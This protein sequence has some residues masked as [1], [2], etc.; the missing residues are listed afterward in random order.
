M[1]ADEGAT[2]FPSVPGYEVVREIGRGG[3]AVVYE[4]RQLSVDRPVALKVV[5]TG[6]LS[7]VTERRFRD[8]LRA[9]GGLSWHPHVVGVHD[10]GLTDDGRPFLAMELVSGGSWGVRVR[11]DGPLPPGRVA[12]LGA[13]VADALQAAHDAGVVH[14][15]VKPDNVLVGR[16]DEALLADFGIAT[17]ADAT[18]TATGTFVGTIAYSPPELL[19]G[20]R[21]TPQSD[22][23]S[24]G[25]LLWALAVGRPAHE[26]AED[27]TPVASVQRVIAEPTP[28]VPEGVPAELAAVIERC[29][30][31][32]PFDRY[33]SARAVQEALAPLAEASRG[34]AA[35]PL[36][37]P[38]DATVVGP[39]PAVAD[40]A[41]ATPVG[42]DPTGPDPDAPTRIDGVAPAAAAAP[43]AGGVDLGKPSEPTPE[44]GPASV[45]PTAGV[46]APA[47]FP[48]PGPFAV[49][50]QPPA[51]GPEPPPG[52]W[53]PAPS[54]PPPGAPAL[55]P[56]PWAPPAD[57]WGPPAPPAPPPW[58]PPAPQWGAPAPHWGPPPAP[59]VKT[60]GLAIA[61]LVTSLVCCPPV[62][63]G[64]T[65]A[66]HLQVRRGTRSGKVLVWLGY[67]AA[68]LVTLAAIG[69]VALG[70]WAVG[71]VNDDYVGEWR[72]GTE[73]ENLTLDLDT[74]F[75]GLLLEG[76]FDARRDGASCRGSIE[77]SDRVVDD[78]SL[79][80]RGRCDDG[81][82]YDQTIDLTL[83]GDDRLVADDG[84][85]F[86]RVGG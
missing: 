38:I 50:D 24:L 25:A 59:A 77:E 27:E 33:P 63:L 85:T 55:P 79:D 81:S 66:G 26:T 51:V 14:R 16:R 80:L 53:E 32:F 35:T 71:D 31:R 3:F 21:A 49:P 28:T 17:L 40:A 20:E 18:M 9:V 67:G 4:A 44:P 23:Y 84:R 13:E 72:T 86:E 34:G 69:F 1:D 39:S 46:P 22:V 43:A 11:A 68:L 76:S 10:G 29:M 30:A 74:A 15:D 5:S 61:G 47:P 2:R 7:A 52:G 19:R 8:E 60:S 48:A 37:S 45:A 82:R 65:I 70:V 62:G 58:S 41:P 56:E 12:R 36:P 73:V 83:V 75:G 57:Q 64:L 54:G 78:I 6:T 42:A